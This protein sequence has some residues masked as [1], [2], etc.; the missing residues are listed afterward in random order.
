MAGAESEAVA[1]VPVVELVEDFGLYPRL[2]VDDMHVRAL[3]E[4]L[5]TRATLPPVVADRKP[6]RLTMAII[7]AGQ[8]IGPRGAGLS[9]ASASSRRIPKTCRTQ[10]G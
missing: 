2:A 7:I 3:A 6:R 9:G 8:T 10:R 4:A 1:V 5:A